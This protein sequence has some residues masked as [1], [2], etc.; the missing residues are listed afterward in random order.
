MI[1][2][3][4]SPLYNLSK[5]ILINRFKYHVINKTRRKIRRLSASERALPDFIVIGAQRAGSTSLFKYLEQ[6]SAIKMSF[7][8]ETFYFT[9]FYNCGES[10]YRA[11]FPLIKS[12]N[13]GVLVGEATPYYLVHPHAPKRISL[14][15]PSVKLIALLRNPKDRAISHYHLSVSHSVEHLSL[16]EALLAEE[17]RISGEWK[18]MLEDENYIS[19]IHRYYSYKQRGIYADQLERYL[20]FFKQEQLLVI[21]CQDLFDSPRTVLKQICIFLGIEKNLGPI[22]FTPRNVAAYRKHVPKEVNNYLDNYFYPH[23]QR[24]YEML[25]RN[26]GW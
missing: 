7:V 12:I 25:D 5:M 17:G 19:D 13:P 1:S 16:M 23:N 21:N 20:N 26:F 24:L 15:L 2:Y 11:N 8:K 14:L 4:K 9:N 22:D 10:W 3:K 18:K 6:L